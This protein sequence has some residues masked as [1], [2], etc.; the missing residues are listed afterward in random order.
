MFWWGGRAFFYSKY[1][2]NWGSYK[3]ISA[4]LFLMQEALKKGNYGYF[5]IL[6]ANSFITK[7]INDVC[8]FFEHQE[9][10]KNYV[11][12]IDLELEDKRDSFNDWL[13][14]YH[15]LH[16]YN[17]K[18]KRGN[19]LDWYFTKLQKYLGIK[20]L[21][22]IK[23]KGYFYAHYTREFVEYALEFIE[24]HPEYF[25]ELKLCYISEEF[26]F[27]NIIMSSPFKNTVYND[28]LIYTSW[29]DHGA[30]FLTERDYDA[31]KSGN[32][33]FARKFG[34]ESEGVFKLICKDAGL[35]CGFYSVSNIKSITES[36]S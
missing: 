2:V 21:V 35:D 28:C 23:Y 32:Y 25:R 4:V 14:Y 11:E 10:L 6:S 17:V 20:R 36:S 22:R 12:V 3:H 9:E 16:V 8:D 30:L 18:N 26:F 5:H 33:L 19:T 34:K 24:N 15:F 1:K 13:H 31:I 7:N 29:D 27:Q